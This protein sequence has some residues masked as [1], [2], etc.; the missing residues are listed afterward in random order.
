MI[1]GQSTQTLTGKSVRSRDRLCA[2]RIPHQA[3]RLLSHTGLAGHHNT[4]YACS[5]RNNRLSDL[6]AKKRFQLLRK[7]DNYD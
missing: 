4:C 2:L 6:E 5:N 3:R 1:R 7:G